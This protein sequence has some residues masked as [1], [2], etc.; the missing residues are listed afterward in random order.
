MCVLTIHC[1]LVWNLSNNIEV[2]ET[3]RKIEQYKKE[4]EILIKKNAVKN[5]RLEISFL[6]CHKRTQ[7]WQFR[8]AKCIL[9]R[10]F[11]NIFE[12]SRDEEYVKSQI[13]AEGKESE[14]RRAQFANVL[15]EEEQSKKKEKEAL[16]DDLVGKVF[17]FYDVV[18]TV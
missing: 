2:D 13:E 15:K 1:F 4:N 12:Q 16:I 6:I 8:V 7:I 5:V 9:L 11:V 18:W 3:N 10:H 17:C 14:E